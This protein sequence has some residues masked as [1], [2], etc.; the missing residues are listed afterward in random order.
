HE[1]GKL[2]ATSIFEEKSNHHLHYKDF[3]ILYRT[4][5][6]SRAMEEALRRHNIKYK[7]VGGLSFYQRKEIKDIVAYLRFVVNQ[8]DEQ[9][10]RRIVNLPKRG[11]GPTSV[12]KIMLEAYEQG[13]PLWDVLIH[14]NQYLP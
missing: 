2:V 6:Q 1:E 3:A 5:S 9:A 8:N 4:N 11:I 7:V 13:I 10:F 14:A 12:D